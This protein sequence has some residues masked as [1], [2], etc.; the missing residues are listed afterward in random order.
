MAN[1][2]G[3]VNTRS[4]NVRPEPSTDRPPVGT[5]GKG[6]RVE[7]IEKAGGW[8]R[9]KTGSL[10]GYVS[11]DYITIVDDTP[12]SDYLWEMGSLVTAQLE[13]TEGKVITVLAKHTAAQK[14]AAKT[15]NGQGGLLEILCGIIDVEPACAVALLCVESGGAGFD[16]GR[17][18]IIR[19]ENHIFWNQWGKNNPAL[20][21]AHF[22]F[23]QQKKWLGHRFRED[24]GGTWVDFHGSQDGEWKA[25]GLARKLDENSAMN[26]IS[27]GGPQIMGFNCS[28]IGYGSVRE[29]FDNFSGNIRYQVL[30]LFD[31]LRGAG[32]TSVMIE[33]LQMKDYTRFASYYNGPGQAPVYG[34][35]IESYV[36][37]FNS[38]QD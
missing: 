19:F 17:R 25:F 16:A 31:F 34:A 3:L 7:I 10:S 1:R 38:L 20:F 26:A 29:M 8:Y 9:I 22:T 14:M 15:W 11:G 35:R 23:N 13:P 2:T 36:K 33:A 27:M 6:D 37:A 24:A 28:R 30:G 18:M 21:N 32:S 4:L 12:V 5:L